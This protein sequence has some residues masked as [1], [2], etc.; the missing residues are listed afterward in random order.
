[1]TISDLYLLCF[2][3][4]FGLS[5]MS[6]VLGDLH[7]HLHLPFHLHFGGVGDVHG[8]HAGHGA[9]HGAG[10]FPVI[11][12]GTITA[13]LAW[14]GGAGYLLTKYTGV[15]ARTVLGLAIIA[16]SVGA[17]IVFLFIAKVLMRHER[18]LDPS[19]YDMIGVLG[20]MSNPIRAGGTGEIVYSQ[21]GTRHVC[22][23]RSETGEA[24]EKGLE[25]VVTRYEK[26][27]AYV[28]PW[29]EMENST[30]DENKTDA[31]R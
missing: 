25:V 10:Q 3:V 2:M 16:G 22:G 26:G 29:E 27:I 7:L 5:L 18:N 28:R 11:N 20:K 6:F 13:F 14:F 9:T 30:T 19:D 21:E 4:G 24:I 8:A 31:S 1:M 12:F 17:S 15:L 23:A